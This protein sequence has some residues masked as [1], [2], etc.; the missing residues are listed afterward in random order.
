MLSLLGSGIVGRDDF[1]Q[2]P[3]GLWVSCASPASLEYI[4]ACMPER[5]QCPRLACALSHMKKCCLRGLAGRVAGAGGAHVHVQAASV[6]CTGR[7]ERHRGS[8]CGESGGAFGLGPALLGSVV[9]AGAR[10]RL[11]G[12]PRKAGHD[13]PLQTASLCVVTACSPLGVQREM[14]E[15]RQRSAESI[16]SARAEERDM[17]ECRSYAGPLVDEEVPSRPVD[18]PLN[19]ITLLVGHHNYANDDATRPLR[20]PYH[21]HRCI[22]QSGASFE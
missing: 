7:S 3:Q 10:Y 22:H 16:S 12:L 4:C 17:I 13:R 2:A 14:I 20:C 8:G 19:Y 9:R 21:R 6:L 15:C 5:V 1:L 11:P 18:V